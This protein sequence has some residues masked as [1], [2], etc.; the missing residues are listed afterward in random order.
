M[1][2]MVTNAL[3]GILSIALGVAFTIFIILSKVPK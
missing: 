1:D 3:S 2:N